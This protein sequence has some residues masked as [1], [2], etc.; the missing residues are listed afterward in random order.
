MLAGGVGEFQPQAQG[1]VGSLATRGMIFMAAP[2]AQHH[3]PSLI[4]PLLLFSD[5]ERLHFATIWVLAVVDTACRQQDTLRPKPGLAR[6]YTK[7]ARPHHTRGW[8]SNT[9]QYRFLPFQFLSKGLQQS[10]STSTAVTR[11]Q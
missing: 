3:H 8:H 11:T 6:C 7:A 10:S 5:L 9:K 2:I 1:I 4:V